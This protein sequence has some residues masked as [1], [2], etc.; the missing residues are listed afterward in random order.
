MKI[1]QFFKPVRG[2]YN[3]LNFFLEIPKI[4]TFYKGLKRPDN[5]ADEIKINSIAKRRVFYF[6]PE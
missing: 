2:D 3:I 5:K 6:I 1:L 4:N